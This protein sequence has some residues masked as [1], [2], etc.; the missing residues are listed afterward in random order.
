M[1][2]YLGKKL[3]EGDEVVFMK[4]EYKEFSKGIITKINKKKL[5]ICNKQ[6]GLLTTRFPGQ[7]I[8]IQ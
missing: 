1:K 3:I 7:V 2:D 6:T 8:R 4:I 5:T